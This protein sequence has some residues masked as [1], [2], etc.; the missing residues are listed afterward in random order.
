MELLLSTSSLSPEHDPSAKEHLELPSLHGYC[1]VPDT[2]CVFLWPNVL[3]LPMRGIQLSCYALPAFNREKH[4]G[5]GCDGNLVFDNVIAGADLTTHLCM[6]VLNVPL[7]SIRRD[8]CRAEYWED[9][10]VLCDDFLR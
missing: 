4:F 9:T 8:M 3:T 10:N 2:Y 1:S 5:I 6:P 7:Q